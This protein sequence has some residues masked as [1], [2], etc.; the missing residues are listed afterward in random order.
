MHAGYYTVV[1]GQIQIKTEVE[2]KWE[3]GTHNPHLEPLA[4]STGHCWAWQF[5]PF[6]SNHFLPSLNKNINSD[7]GQLHPSVVLH[8]KYSWLNI[9]EG[10]TEHSWSVKVSESFRIE[11][12]THFK[13]THYTSQLLTFFSSFQ[14]L[15]RHCY[16]MESWK[17]PLSCRQI[18]IPI[19]FHTRNPTKIFSFQQTQQYP[20]G[21]MTC[22]YHFRGAI[23]FFL[24][25]HPSCCRKFF[26]SSW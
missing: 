17:I 24:F 16:F 23:F 25:F 5:N 20:A 1:E 4:I 10:G 11:H 18:I 8:I 3:W 13:H 22:C 7:A 19:Q 15:A 12:T 26:I 6:H 2:I 14:S 21:E 9:R